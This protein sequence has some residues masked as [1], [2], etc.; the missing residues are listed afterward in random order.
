MHWF[1]IVPFLVMIMMFAFFAYM[2]RRAGGCGWRSGHRTLWT[3]FG[4]CSSRKGP[5]T[6]WWAEMPRQILDR[7]YASGEITNEQY[8]RIKRDIESDP[9]Q[10]GP[11]DPS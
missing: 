1:W 6:R 5:R 8:E 9:S 7:L 2:I 3:P 4:C 10:N 11:S